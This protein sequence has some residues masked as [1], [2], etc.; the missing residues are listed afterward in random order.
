M[1]DINGQMTTSKFQQ[2]MSGQWNQKVLRKEK[3]SSSGYP[4]PDEDR[5]FD[6]TQTNSDFME[7]FNTTP[8]EINSLNATQIIKDFDKDYLALRSKLIKLIEYQEGRL[9]VSQINEEI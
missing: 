7:G 4:L 9:E 5:N 1:A 8:K 3:Y 2:Q 6:E